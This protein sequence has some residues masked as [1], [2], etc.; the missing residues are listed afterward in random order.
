MN[1]AAL[2]TVIRRGYQGTFWWAPWRS[3]SANMV[4]RPVTYLLTFGILHHQLDLGT[5]Q[6]L[7]LALITY[8]TLVTVVTCANHCIQTDQEQGTFTLAMST[9]VSPAILWLTRSAAQLPNGLVS[10]V[11]ALLYAAVAFDVD[12]TEV[13]A[14]AVAAIGATLVTA[15]AVAML[16]GLATRRQGAWVGPVSLSTGVLLVL[17][18]AVIPRDDLPGMLQAVSAFV[19]LAHANDAVRQAFGLQSGNGWADVAAELAL[20]AALGALALILF[21]RSVR[22]ARTIGTLTV[23]GT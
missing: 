23:E 6:G 21:D 17:S 5:T 22:R 12:L 2:T 19:P 14:L 9:P 3:W 10:A 13:D 18:G 8:S 16:V 7:V 11:A 1:A 4:I 20:A 15:L